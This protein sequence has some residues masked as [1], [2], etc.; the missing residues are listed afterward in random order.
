MGIYIL[1]EENLLTVWSVIE[2]QNPRMAEVGR[3]FWNSPGPTLPAQAGPPI[4]PVG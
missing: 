1:K 2:L 4:E 3:D